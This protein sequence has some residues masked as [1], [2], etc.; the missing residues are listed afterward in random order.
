V[1]KTKAGP[2]APYAPSPK[3]TIHPPNGIIDSYLESSLQEVFD[4]SMKTG[5]EEGLR[6]QVNSDKSVNA[7]TRVSLLTRV[8]VH[9]SDVNRRKFGTS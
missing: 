6:I 2:E 3:L 8:E 4:R 9:F 7:D 1:Q 5:T